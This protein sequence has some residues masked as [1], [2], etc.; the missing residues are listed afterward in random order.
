MKNFSCEKIPINNEDGDVSD[1][2]IKFVEVVRTN[3]E[4]TLSFSLESDGDGVIDLATQST[5]DPSHVMMFEY[6][7]EEF[8]Y[9]SLLYQD[10]GQYLISASVMTQTFTD[11]DNDGDMDIVCGCLI[12]NALEDNDDVQGVSSNFEVSEETL[13]SL[14]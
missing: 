1:L 2:S 10:T 8:E 12:S 7:G 9:T 13:A 11:I 6:N 3:G 4:Y 14:T 5:L